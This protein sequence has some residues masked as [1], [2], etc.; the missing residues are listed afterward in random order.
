MAATRERRNN[1]GT[2]MSKLLDEEEEDEFYKT[3]YGGFEEAENDQEY[4]SEDS[5]DDDVDSDFSI[6][7]NDDVISDHEDD[8]P[9]RAKRLVTKA[10]R[11]PKKVT[12]KEVDVTDKPFPFN[13]P[14]DQAGPSNVTPVKKPVVKKSSFTPSR[15]ERKSCRR[16]TAAKS[17]EL[18]KR[19]KQR[20]E[21]YQRRRKRMKLKEKPDK[22]M[23][24]EELL[25][26]AKIT[27]RENLE[28][29]EQFQ[30]M[31]LEKKKIRPV[32]KIYKGPM[33]RY[34]SFAAPLIEELPSSENQT[35]DVDDSLIT[36]EEIKEQE[37]VSND[38]KCER[39]FI[40]FPDEKSLKKYFPQE[41]P[42]LKPVKL[43]PFSRQPARYFDPVVKLPFSNVVSFRILR[44]TYESKLETI[45]DKSDPEV[46]KWLAWR[47]KQQEL[48]TLVTRKLQQMVTNI[49]P[50]G[51]PGPSTSASTPTFIR[52]AGQTILTGAPTRPAI[53]IQKQQ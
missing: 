52:T 7:E 50:S 14:E 18:R 10:Y 45:G 17:A 28:S 42:A 49:K 40:T 24:Q 1:A 26:E 15:S 36:V 30:L 39:T 13:I 46:A 4:K 35:I 41:K 25:E 23:T 11:E 37:I 31:E 22:P 44:S 47:K 21:E 20:D 51:D 38:K 3:T 29:L 2:R 34:H 6:D 8:K 48:R 32:K 12:K 43:C 9:K 53:F 27:E 33:I 19:V 5:G 16:S